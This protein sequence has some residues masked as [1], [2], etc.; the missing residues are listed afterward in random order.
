MVMYHW[1]TGNGHASFIHLRGSS[2]FQVRFSLSY[3]ES[4]TDMNSDVKD[5]ALINQIDIILILLFK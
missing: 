4:L 1:P 3:L 2:Y 5:V